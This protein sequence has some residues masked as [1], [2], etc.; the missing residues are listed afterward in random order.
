MNARRKLNTAA[1]AGL[2]LA[3]LLIGVAAQ[4]WLAFALALLVLGGLA[5]YAGLVRPPGPGGKP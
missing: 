5:V 1:L 3:A 2:G 4:S